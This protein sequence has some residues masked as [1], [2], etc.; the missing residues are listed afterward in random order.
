MLTA[1]FR[2]FPPKLA[3][4]FDA[5]AWQHVPVA[6]LTRTWHG[7][8]AP[9]GL[10][11]AV[12]LLWTADALWL[13]FTCRF[14][15]LDIDDVVDTAAERHGLWERDVCE[16]FVQSPHEPS[17]Q[18]YKEFEV[19]PTGQWFDV[20][21]R[22]PRLDIDWAW[23]GGIAT[24]AAIDRTAG[25]WRA[26][27]RVPFTAFGGAPRSGETWRANLFRIGRVG[28]VRHFLAFAPTGT[29]QPDFHVPD[30]FVALRFERA[31]S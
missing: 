27:L 22:T 1:A 28:G 10:E 17:R 26:T 18:S 4:A 3:A 12:R 21:I 30:A 5:P 13:G 15:E 6:S 29:P 16:V 2:A 14:T 7:D 23:D 20:A 8:A 24:A 11:T 19:A 31:D 9:A 25:E